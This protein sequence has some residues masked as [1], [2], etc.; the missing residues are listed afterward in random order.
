MRGWNCR[1]A[2]AIRAICCVSGPAGPARA[3]ALRALPG[4][5]GVVGR[6]P[7]SCSYI[8][9]NGRLH[10][11]RRGPLLPG[12]VAKNQH[13]VNGIDCRRAQLRHRN[14][15]PRMTQNGSIDERHVRGADIGSSGADRP[16]RSDPDLVLLAPLD[17][18][19]SPLGEVPD[20]VFADKM[21]GDG[22]AIDPTGSVLCSALRRRSHS[23]ACGACMPSP[24][25]PRMAPKS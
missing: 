16:C 12:D 17:G 9:G 24:C 6:R 13:H 21:M 5:C 23:A 11:F 19:V 18:W 22:L 7:A 2:S 25:A 20:P 4:T 1:K 3:R 14:R 15:S 8:A 10:P